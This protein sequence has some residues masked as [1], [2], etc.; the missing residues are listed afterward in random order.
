VRILLIVVVA[1]FLV[2]WVGAVID[3]FRRSDLTGLGKAGWAIGMLVFPV[4][5]LGVY[6]LFR[7]ARA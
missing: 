5:G 7:A 3:V 1:L 4:I 6:T 2:L